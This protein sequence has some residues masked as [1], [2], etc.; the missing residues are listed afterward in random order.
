MVNFIICDDNTEVTTQIKNFIS[1]YMMKNSI[2]YKTHVFNDYDDKFMKLMNQKLPFKIYI[3]DIEVPSRS[4]IDIA[5][6][7]RNN[8]SDSII[9]FLTG[10]EELGMTIL[11]DEIMCLSFINKFDNCDAKMERTITKALKMLNKKIK[12]KLHNILKNQKLASYR[13]K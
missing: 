12:V 11:K 6:T 10:H 9:I 3:L 4:G 8:D 7:I 5:R 2:E 1:D 13:S